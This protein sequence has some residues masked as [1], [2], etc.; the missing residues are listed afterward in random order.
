MIRSFKAAL[1]AG[2]VLAGGVVA[3]AADGTSSAARPGK[4]GAPA[5]ATAAGA[6]SPGRVSANDRIAAEFSIF[7][8]SPDNAHCLVT[9]LRQ[10]KEVVLTASSDRAEDGPSAVF[11]PPTR[12]MDGE[13]VRIALALAQ[14]QLIRLGI[15]HPT[16]T[17]IKAALAGGT[18]TSGSGRS[19][20]TTTLQGVLAMRALGIGWVQIAST[21]GAKLSHVMAGLKQTN[22]QLASG[23]PVPGAA[24]AATA[25]LPAAAAFGIVAGGSA[26]TAG[27]AVAIGHARP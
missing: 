5:A 20:A 13:N 3:L 17:Q 14:E 15:T 18:V 4:T 19:T 16:V 26:S 10:G 21:M 27:Q 6:V 2:A 22:Q 11:T 1:V 7:A 12:P 9:G 23:R 8:G 24:S 25:E